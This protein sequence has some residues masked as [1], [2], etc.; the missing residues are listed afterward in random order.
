M[1]N[2][3]RNHDHIPFGQ[4]PLLAA[5]EFLTARFPGA[6]GPGFD[7]FSPSNKRR[8]AFQNVENIGILIMNLHLAWPSSAPGLYLEVVG[9]QQWP[10]LGK[11]CCDRFMV[12]LNHAG[13]F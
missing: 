3:S 10:S 8:R 5:D 2:A 11:Y 7:R 1:R 12:E 6:N 13:F 9:R 4:L